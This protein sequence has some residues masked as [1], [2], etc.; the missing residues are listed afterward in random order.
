[1]TARSPMALPPGFFPDV[2]NLRGGEGLPR[3][4]NGTSALG[5]VAA[6]GT[7]RGA[8]QGYIY[9]AYTIF[10]AVAVGGEIL[11]YS[12]TDAATWTEATAGSGAY[13]DTRFTDPSD[14]VQFALVKDP[15]ETEP[16][17]VMVS[18]VG[19]SA[20]YPLVF[21]PSGVGSACKHE[22]V[23][24]PTLVR[25]FPVNQT[26]QSF[27]PLNNSANTTYTVSTA[28]EFN[29]ADATVTGGASTTDNVV[30][31]TLDSTAN[32][33]ET[34]R[35]TFASAIDA[36]GG[37]LAIGLDTSYVEFWDR[38]RVRLM[39]AGTPVLT[40]WDPAAT[41]TTSAPVPVPVD[42]TQKTIWLFD[43]QTLVQNTTT[44]FDGVE[45][46]YDT[47]I[48]AAPATDQTADI[49]M[50][51]V[52]GKEAGGTQ[53]GVSYM[54]SGSRGESAGVV[55]STYK[56]EE[57]RNLGGPTYNGL[58]L[59][60]DQRVLFKFL[61][62]Y[63]N[64]STGERD[65][66][67]DRLMV[68]RKRV[69]DFR[70][71]HY[72]QT[73]IAAYA[74]GWAYSASGTDV[75]QLTV[76]SGLNYEGRVTMPDGLHIPIPK[77]KGTELVNGRLFV[78]G[79]VNGQNTIL[80]SE[81]GHPF[82][83]REVVRIDDQG[84]VDEYSP[85]F[86]RLGNEVPQ[87][88]VGI[89]GGRTGIGQGFVFTDS[90]VYG[91]YGILTSQITNAG[92]VA[93]WG[94]V[95]PYSV[96]EHDG[97]VFWLARDMQVRR[98]AGE[99]GEISAGVVDDILKDIP[100]SRRQFAWGAWFD[101]S[102]RLAYTP[103]SGS[104]NSRILVWDARTGVW[105]SR[106]V[107]PTSAQGLLNW[108]DGASN[109]RE[110]LILFGLDSTTLKSYDY[111]AEGVTTDLGANIAVGLTTPEFVNLDKKT[112]LMVKRIGLFADK[113][114]AETITYTRTYKPDA[115]TSTSTASLA[116]S[117]AQVVLWDGQPALSPA[118]AAGKGAS[119]QVSLSASMV[120]G[121][122]IYLWQAEV[123]EVNDGRAG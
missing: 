20:N 68:Y 24:A 51:A 64:T 65:K 34:A 38:I 32:S 55:Y 23:T 5:T 72:T 4:R 43:L 96:V 7:L 117:S 46:M 94:T 119:V 89:S 50:I 75:K 87:R 81:Y 26:F 52:T 91:F 49:W 62:P 95:A 60:N 21:R 76:N 85:G 39:S 13:G 33:D 84:N 28:G 116:S 22:P 3:V 115:N 123:D 109:K 6:S 9:G 47:S 25:D 41:S 80:F 103:T 56:T 45:L 57:V 2:K 105:V 102:Y 12:S 77:G 112:F 37:Q 1:M 10:A 8:W 58:R 66:G 88:I 114:A 99:V 44:N 31:V 82:R 111:D 48:G 42:L 110:R 106:D 16:H 113:T 19:S 83:F 29:M 97:Q 108:F 30:R 59:P 17:M 61:L 67:V 15:L 69:E 18:G 92:R 40:V 27:F 54:N 35:V 70:F 74:A 14:T 121:N 120:G 100:G 122:R 86:F 71:T 107:P 104:S 36:N 118:T 63:L 53:F 101:Q 78:G 93:P 73:T 98:M 11:V 79:Q 90:A